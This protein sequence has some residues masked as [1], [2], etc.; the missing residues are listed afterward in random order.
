MPKGP[1]LAEEGRIRTD[2]EYLAWADAVTR[3][4]EDIFES[5]DYDRWKDHYRSRYFG[6][7]PDATL[8]ESQLRGLWD[9][10]IQRKFTSFPGAGISTWRRETPTAYYIQYRDVVTGRY[11]SRDDA[12][13]KMTE[14]EQL[15]RGL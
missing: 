14:W 5:V 2:E 3:D 1:K 7:S 10:G 8:A 11:L 9:K 15:Q 4:L 13:S 6:L 12:M